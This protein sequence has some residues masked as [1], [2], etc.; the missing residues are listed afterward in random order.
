MTKTI[1][2]SQGKVALVSDE[3]HEWLNQWKWSALEG[4]TTWYAVRHDYSIDPPDFL[5]MHRVI[6]RPLPSLTV[7]H[8]NDD[9]LDNQRG[10]LQVLT[11]REHRSRHNRARWQERGKRLRWFGGQLKL[12]RLARDLT[13]EELGQMAGI[14]HATI[15]QL[16]R[17]GYVPRDKT[18]QKL[19]QA[20]RWPR[21][22]DVA[23]EI[24]MGETG[25]EP[26]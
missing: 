12:I 16:E 9:G 20:L 4:R 1:P 19:K 24:L 14:S 13:Q 25:A 26:A 2:L 5:Y 15:S 6:V 21:D 10:N 11:I 17:N 3:D 22:A 8:L 18:M 23:F 7:N